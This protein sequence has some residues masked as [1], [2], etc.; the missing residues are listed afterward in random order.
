MA[1]FYPLSR[2]LR[3]FFLLDG[4]V[5]ML[6]VTETFAMGV[7][8]PT[9]WVVFSSMRK[10]DGKGFMDI[11]PRE[12]TQTAGRRGLD[13]AGAVILVVCDSLPEV[14]ALN[15]M[16]PGVPGNPSSQLRLSKKQLGLPARL[17]REKCTT[18]IDRYY[19]FS[20]ALVA[21]KG[22][23]IEIVAVRRPGLHLLLGGQVIVLRDHHFKT[24]NLAL[25][26]KA[27]PVQPAEAGK[28]NKGKVYYVLA[29]VDQETK[30]RRRHIDPQPAVPRSTQ[31]R[32]S[33]RRLPTARLVKGE[34][35][36]LPGMESYILNNKRVSFAEC[37]MVVAL[38]HT[39]MQDA[40][41]GT[42]VEIAF[43]VIMNTRHSSNNR[44][45]LHDCPTPPK[46]ARKMEHWTIRA[47]D[48]DEIC[49]AAAHFYPDLNWVSVH[50]TRTEEINRA[51]PANSFDD[52]CQQVQNACGA[53]T[54]QF[55][56]ES[57]GFM[58]KR[59]SQ[60]AV[61]PLVIEEWTIFDQR[62]DG[63]EHDNIQLEALVSMLSLGA[64]STLEATFSRLRVTSGAKANASGVP[65]DEGA[66]TD[67]NSVL[68]SRP[69]RRWWIPVGGGLFDAEFLN[70]RTRVARVLDEGLLSSGRGRGEGLEL[71]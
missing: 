56:D 65:E 52:G 9:H 41:S 68:L 20:L 17:D 35:T 60:S 7:N 18:D 47:Y 42:N 39:K 64:S 48:S 71:P 5:E 46:N 29:T 63:L 61:D 3:K 45:V 30:S 38:V 28:I 14:G 58:L 16:I 55:D 51:L 33:P 34:V 27:G 4:L 13:P 53:W 49:V 11:I 67:R 57:S 36:F 24:N 62:A 6:F 54:I 8:M 21:C 50:G 25:L 59:W 2:Y 70:G 19:N 15:I 22:A 44:Q 37:R 40:P 1:V 43:T 23:M 66:H 26:L 10:H 32:I 12:Y 31:R 69:T